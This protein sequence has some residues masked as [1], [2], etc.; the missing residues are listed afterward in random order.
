MGIATFLETAIDNILVSFV[1]SKSAALCSALVP[2]ALTGTTVYIII[3]GWAVMRG[4]AADPFHTVL[5][6]WFKI[7]FVA[8]IALSAGEYQGTVVEAVSAIPGILTQAFGNAATVGAMVDNAADPLIALGSQLMGEA[9][10]PYVPNITLLA[11]AALVAL[12]ELFMFIVGLGMYLVA[13][14][15][16]A[17]LLAV[18]PIFILCLM[19]PAAQSKFEGWL[20]ATLGFAFLQ[21]LIG[22]A[23]GMLYDIVTKVAAKVNTTAG[24]ANILDDTLALFAITI[25]LC[26]VLLGLKEV[27]AAITGGT[28]VQGLGQM[29]GRAIGNWL[30][31][32]SKDDKPPPAPGP[33]NEILNGT[34]KGRTDGLS[35]GGDSGKGGGQPLYQRHVLDNIRKGATR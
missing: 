5:W 28:T 12:A 16:L 1:S 21:G 33:D 29:A 4:E 18:G 25:T 3:M 17:L 8:G 22:A 11:S 6:K 30:N 20:G 23:I 26:V 10:T 9:T 32:S 2:I 15:T 13:K 35:S 14:V 24:V 27:S 34:P 7:S 19:W 31:K